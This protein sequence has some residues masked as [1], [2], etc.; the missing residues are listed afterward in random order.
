MTAYLATILDGMAMGVVL[1]VIA[2]GLAL[3]LGAADLLNLAHGSFYLLGAVIGWRAG[4]GTWRGLATAAAIA[5]GVGAG[6]GLAL[7]LVLR[8]LIRTG[9]LR[10]ALATIGIGLLIADTTSVATGGQTVLPAVPAALT[11]S[12]TVAGVTYP[13]YRLVFVAFALPAA[14]GLW[15]LVEKSRPGLLVRAAATDAPMVQ[16]LGVP[17][18][19]LLAGALSVGSAV[20][21]TAGAFAAPIIAGAPGVDQHLLVSALT[22]IVL[23]GITSLRA[24]FAASLVL[25]QVD[26]LGVAIWPQA[27]A[28]V[29]LGLLIT[30][31][32]WRTRHA[33][34][35]VAP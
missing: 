10:Q 33:S 12:V 2:A 21:V 13:L 32:T 18:Q 4:D 20:A 15:W 22:V 27:T 9:H 26:T 3:I 35:P 5:V 6:A 17:P 29:V 11:G 24:I 30:A 23:G 34:S 25:G 19:L 7:Q 28:F 16:T 14:I 1:F 8:P 31:V